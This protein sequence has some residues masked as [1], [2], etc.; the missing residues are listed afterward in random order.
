MLYIMCVD[1]TGF[2]S[3]LNRQVIDCVQI[4]MPSLSVVGPLMIELNFSFLGN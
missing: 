4:I 1:Y 2:V 3:I